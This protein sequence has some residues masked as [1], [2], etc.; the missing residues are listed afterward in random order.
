[1]NEKFAADKSFT[2]SEYLEGFLLIILFKIFKIFSAICS[3]K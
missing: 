2:F 1:M 3:L